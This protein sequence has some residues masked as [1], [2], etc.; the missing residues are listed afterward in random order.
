MCGVHILPPPAA[1]IPQC[2][3]LVDDDTDVCVCVYAISATTTCDVTWLAFMRV[4]YRFW[5]SRCLQLRFFLE[6]GGMIMINC[7]PTEERTITSLGFDFHE[8]VFS[9]SP[10]QFI[11]ITES[12][13]VSRSHS[14][15]ASH[16]PGAKLVVMMG[17]AGLPSQPD[18]GD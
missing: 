6:R 5:T 17:G 8:A 10:L 18:D 16:R 14:L 13:D 1:I 15:Q 7:I 2:L 12:I 3:F 11:T 4:P 9:I